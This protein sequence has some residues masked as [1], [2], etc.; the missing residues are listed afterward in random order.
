MGII[1]QLE[2]QHSLSARLSRAFRA[3]Q[4]TEL[5]RLQRDQ[6]TSDL[7][8][9]S[10][11]ALE[12]GFRGRKDS[13]SY[14]VAI[15]YMEKDNHIYRDSEFFNVSDGATKHQ[16]F[17]LELKW[18][19]SSQIEF[20]LSATHALHRYRHS[21]NIDGIEIR[22]NDI[23]SAPRYFGNAQILWRYLDRTQF[24]LEWQVMGDYFLDPEN[25]NNY[26]GHKVFNL[27]S[28]H[29][30]SDQ[31]KLYARLINVTDSAYA[32]RADYTSFSGHRYFPGQPRTLNLGIEWQ[33]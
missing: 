24:E 12:L 32:E 21:R 23:D 16:G 15:Y 1:Y 4:A 18:Q 26:P 19:L 28:S 20:N 2:I 3:P 14:N 17:E 7:K 27:R 29:R 25:L 13:L 33:W 31:L 11:S 5:Y 8:P 22:G 6:Q 9:E 10:I 30:L